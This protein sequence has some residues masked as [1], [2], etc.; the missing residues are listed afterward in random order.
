MRRGL[1]G[2]LTLAV[3]GAL[4]ATPPPTPPLAEVTGT[5]VWRHHAPRF[6][7]LSAIELEPDALGFIV[8]SDSAA[9]FSGRF[10]RGAD[11]EVVGATVGEAVL[12]VSWHGTPLQDWMDDAEGLAF[13]PDGGIYVSYESWDR[14][15]HYGPGGRGWKDEAGPDE[16]AAFPANQGIEA[17]AVDAAGRVLAIPE[18][19]PH[20]GDTPVYRVSGK[21]ARV[22]FTLR[23][24]RDWS[25]TGADI[26][27]DGRLYLL[28]RG[29]W[30]FLGFA[31]RVRRI[32]LDHDRVAA[33]VVIW[34]SEPG[35]HDNLE[36]IAAWQD[37]AGGLRLT[38]V[39]D[40]NFLPV[41]KTEIVDLRMTE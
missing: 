19:P 24:D 2:G 30:P 40:D 11:G 3:L 32:T 33:D 5:Y 27:P 31:S 6:G 39:S 16:F 38:M 18:V 10:T 25:S 13:A 34:Q 15:V 26:G 8:V 1:G 37:A 14:I 36:G 35:H 9:F 28:E 22:I 12:P 29:F 20:G 41:Q 7:G 21:K 23:H 4:V 17:L